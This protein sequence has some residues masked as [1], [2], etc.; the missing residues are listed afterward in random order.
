MPLFTATGVAG[1]AA[2]T[3]QPHFLQNLAL[4]GNASPHCTQFMGMPSKTGMPSQTAHHISYQCHFYY[5]FTTRMMPA[6][7]VQTGNS[8]ACYWD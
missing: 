5:P 2:P 1:T 3:L 7:A 4:S 6:E 8:R